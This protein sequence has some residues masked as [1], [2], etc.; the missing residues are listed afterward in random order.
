M[1][2][3]GLRISNCD[4][5]ILRQVPFLKN[6]QFAIRNPQ[7]SSLSGKFR[8]TFVDV[9]INAFFRILR[10]KQLLLQ[11][12]LEREPGLEWNLGAGLNTAFNP[13]DGV[14]CFSRRCKL[15]RIVVDLALKITGVRGVQNFVDKAE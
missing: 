7:F 13:A 10:L 1:A 4:L 15:L 5:I 12:T 11:F 8:L 6:P 9:S 3:G 14:R 2:D